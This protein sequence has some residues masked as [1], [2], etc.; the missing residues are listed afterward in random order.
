MT[1]FKSFLE[2]TIK[3][4]FKQKIE[5]IEKIEK[6]KRRLNDIRV[7][8]S[9]RE[10]FRQEAIRLN[11][12]SK[13]LGAKLEETNS[14]LKSTKIE[15]MNLNRKWKESEIT[16]KQL[17]F[18]L[19][20][21]IKFSKELDDRYNNLLKEKNTPNDEDISKFNYNV[22]EN[23]SKEKEILQL[24]SENNVNL[25]MDKLVKMIDK[26]KIDLKIEKIRNHKI[27]CEFNKLS[28]NRDQIEKIFESCVEDLKK[29]IHERR[30]KELV[31]IKNSPPPIELKD[32]KIDNFSFVDKKKLLE[33]F[34]T[35]EDVINFIKDHFK[36]KRPEEINLIKI[37]KPAKD[38]NKTQ[39]SFPKAE[40]KYK[41]DSKFK[42]FSKFANKMNS[43]YNRSHII[44]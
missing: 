29:D 37:F 6:E 10:F 2:T 1:A 20:R 36:T 7:I 35:N 30:L 38:F 14:D 42:I 33:K 28:V 43:I 40:F 27:L 5:E 17:I 34:I 21:N 16:N 15:L 11:N 4:E 13:D 18:E 32:I 24:E 22:K 41:T 9:E 31:S 44:L 23:F 3:K 39:S 19:E 12:L 25:S 26:L 8:K